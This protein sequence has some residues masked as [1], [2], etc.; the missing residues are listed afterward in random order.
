MSQQYF[1]EEKWV[2]FN[3]LGIE[4]QE[5]LEKWEYRQTAIRSHEILSDPQLIKTQAFN[6]DRQKEIHAHLLGD[7]YEW[8]GK[9]RTVPSRKLNDNREMAIFA[10][11]EQIEPNWQKI[12]QQCNE[13]LAS[14]QGLAEKVEQL[15]EILAQINQTHAFPEGNGRTTQIFMK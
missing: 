8:A 13:F 5:E 6:L 14:R 3:K 2:F 15:A 7:I 10:E 1:D 9:I 12:E 11:P 4:N